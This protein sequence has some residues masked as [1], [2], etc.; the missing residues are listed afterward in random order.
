[1]LRKLSLGLL[2]CFI[3]IL[4]HAQTLE[5]LKAQKADLA[6]GQAVEQAKVDSFAAEIAKLDGQIEIL[7]GWQT[8]FDGV[9]GLNFG[10]SNNW[11]SNANPNSSFSNLSIGLNAYANI[12]KEKSF[13]RNN[14]ISNTGW[15]S[16]DVDTDDDTE[17]QSFLENRTTDV[18]TVGSLYGLRLNQD[19]AISALAD[20]NSSVFNF[21]EPGSLDFGA[22]ATYTP[23][24]LPN[25]VA[26][27]HPLTYHIAFPSAD[28]PIETTGGLGSKIKITYNKS[29]KGGVNWST[30]FGTF[31]PYSQPA[32]DSDEA[33][34]FEYTWINTVSFNVWK[35]IGVGLNFGIR[36][37]EFE[38]DGTQS[39]STLGISYGF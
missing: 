14:F 22:G 13:W 36:Q 24:Q 26:V 28:S 31:I 23:H 37:A 18:L 17:E 8:G 7:S 4:S 20:F 10:S 25:F 1:M 32:P 27:I 12:I 19:F 3:S 5:E 2:L 30:N 16:L 29:F 11:Q 35:G 34:L 39:F 6:A 38:F 21:L 33:P 9:I 15:Q